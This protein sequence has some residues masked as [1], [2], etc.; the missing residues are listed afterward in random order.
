MSALSYKEVCLGL[1]VPR[2]TR[3]NLKVIT[4][5]CPTF[6]YNAAG[7]ALVSRSAMSGCRIF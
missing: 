3:I 6:L 4:K 5:K 1:S 7:N 2:D